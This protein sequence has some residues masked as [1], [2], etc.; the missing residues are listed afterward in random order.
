MSLLPGSAAMFG[1]FERS[2]FRRRPPWVPAASCRQ[3]RSNVM[4]FNRCGSRMQRASAMAIC[5]ACT[6]IGG[7]A[8]RGQNVAAEQPTTQPAK[9]V[10]KQEHFDADPAWDAL[11][12]RLKLEAKDLPIVDQN[13]GYSPTQFAGGAKGE[14]GGKIWRSVTPAHYADKIAPKT[15][16]D[17][18]TAS[19]KLTFTDM[20][21]N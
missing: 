15:L 11:N 5:F 3:A 4:K 8:A 13:F 21:S 1:P 20:A 16:N 17:K 14:I 6:S 10:F 2:T 12:N 19:G 9:M 18:L 7:L